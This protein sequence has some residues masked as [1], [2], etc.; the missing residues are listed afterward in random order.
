MSYNTMFTSFKNPRAISLVVCHTHGRMACNVK[1]GQMEP[2]LH[3]ACFFKR[4]LASESLKKIGTKYLDV[5]MRSSTVQKINMK[6]IV[7]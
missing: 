2:E 3:V 5:I 6:I 4:K 7:F 1:S